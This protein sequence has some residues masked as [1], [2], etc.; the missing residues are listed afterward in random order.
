MRVSAVQKYG[1]AVMEALNSG[2]VS[3]EA[4]HGILSGIPRVSG[5]R[6]RR[7]PSFQTGGLISETL[8]GA[9]TEASRAAQ[10]AQGQESIQRG[11]V[12]A[13]VVP[14]EQSF[15]RMIQGGDAALLRFMRENRNTINSTLGNNGGR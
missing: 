5:H 9:A 7:V 11:V 12:A 15:D 10:A 14:D 4:L 13:V 3:A 2:R 1:P 8:A 6:S